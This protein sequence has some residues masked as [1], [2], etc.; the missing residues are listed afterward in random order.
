MAEGPRFRRPER[1]T[2]PPES[3]ELLFGQLPRRPGG[4]PALWSHQADILRTYAERH[5]ATADVAL[6]LPTGSGKTLVGLLV[7]EW[8]RRA[9]GH[10]VAYVCPTKQLAGQVAA[11]AA[12]QG[13]SVAL[14][15]GP[16]DEWPE[17]HKSAYTRAASIA[18]TTYSTIFQQPPPPR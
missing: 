10:R 15:V 17:Q 18:V 2:P 12:A 5:S 1:A 13:I 8:R 16:H 14:L 3:P 9:L 4:V 11:A 7:A 6:E